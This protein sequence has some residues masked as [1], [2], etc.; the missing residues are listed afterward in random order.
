[1]PLYPAVRQTG[2]VVFAG[3]AVAASIVMGRLGWSLEADCP[4]IVCGEAL[5]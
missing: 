1:M 3:R 2:E 5:S 4:P